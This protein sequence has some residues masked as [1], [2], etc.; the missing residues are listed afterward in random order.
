MCASVVGRDLAEG[1]GQVTTASINN[2]L[3]LLQEI[4]RNEHWFPL[5]N[6]G[7]RYNQNISVTLLT[8]ECIKYWFQIELDLVLKKI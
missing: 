5:E 7:A 3:V 8:N 1:W 2:D 4:R 6:L